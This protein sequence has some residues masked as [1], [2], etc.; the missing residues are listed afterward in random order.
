MNNRPVS[1]G[2]ESL[3]AAEIVGRETEQ[4]QIGAFVD[5]G[6]DGVRALVIRGDPGIGKT[7]LWQEAVQACRRAGYEVLVTRPAEEELSLALAGLVDLFEH[8][9]LDTAG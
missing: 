6:A 5:A 2:F 4:A 1:A 9:G 8:H 3:R 7:T